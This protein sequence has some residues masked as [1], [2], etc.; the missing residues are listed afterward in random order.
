M[1]RQF[2]SVH[3]GLHHVLSI[4]TEE[5]LH[6]FGESLS[7][8]LLYG[9]A[10]GENFIPGKSNVNLL[11]VLKTLN[12]SHLQKYQ[13]QSLQWKKKGID[14]PLFC[15]I[16]F[17]EKSKDVFPIEW[18]EI[19]SHHIILHGDNPF[20]FTIDH[21]DLRR[22]CEKEVMEIQIRLRQAFLEA[23][24]S[25]EEIERLALTSLNAVFPVLRALLTLQKE[26]PPIEREKLIELFFS[27]NR[28]S[29]DP[30]LKIWAIKKGRTIPKEDYLRW[31]EEYLKQLEEL[32][33]LIDQI[34]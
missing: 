12:F 18:L 20:S 29:P 27:Q 8:L 15:T 21:D 26:S 5:M 7:S 1:T 23:Q 30:F 32:S 3:P 10:A 17:L 24:S 22:Q 11:L 9:S 25:P 6:L 16:E 19:I 4:F 31:F 33:N 2:Q 28:L 14:P 34:K 13:K